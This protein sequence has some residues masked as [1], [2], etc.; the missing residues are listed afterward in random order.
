MKK[1]GF[2]RVSPNTEPSP[3]KGNKKLV[4]DEYNCNDCDYQGN[5]QESLQK[6]IRFTHTME[7]YKC[8]DCDYQGT[9]GK[10]LY[11]HKKTE[12]IQVQCNICQYL[13]CGEKELN[14]HINLKH[15]E[16]NNKCEHNC[17]EVDESRKH[18]NPP[19]VTERGFRCR[20]CEKEFTLKSNLMSHRKSEHPN[21]VAPCRNYLEGHCNRGYDSCWWNHKDGE[22][23]KIERYFCD[24]TLYTKHKV[25]VHRK[26]EHPRTVK[27]CRQFADSKCPFNDETCWFKHEKKPEMNAN[28]DFQESMVNLKIT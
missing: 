24:K 17:N 16:Q 23:A 11:A 10:D 21:T 9:E 5:T 27:I 22:Q 14:K 1:S 8:S 26:I 2:K 13:C 12:H 18:L 4:E 7:K 25:M 3:I 15:L 28:S 20:H 6:H 19:H